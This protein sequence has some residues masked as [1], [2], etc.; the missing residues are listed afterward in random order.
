MRIARSVGVLGSLL[1]LLTAQQQKPAVEPAPQQE[2][3]QEERV[4]RIFRLPELGRYDADLPV[5]SPP[6]AY[7]LLSVLGRT[8]AAAKWDVVR[9]VGVQGGDW[10]GLDVRATKV[11]IDAVQSVFEQ[12]QK[13]EPLQVG[14]Q[15]SVVTLPWPVAEALNL[16]NRRT[17][18]VDAETVDKLVREA[19]KNKGTLC[20]LP[21][22]T[23]GTLAPFVVESP[24]KPDA[25]DE[26][27][28]R[29]L[30]EMVPLDDREVAVAMHLV[31]GVLPV[32]KT[33]EPAGALL[34]PVL[35]LQAGKCALATV[36]EGATATVLVVRG[37]DVAAQAPP[38]G[39][40]LLAPLA[41]GPCCR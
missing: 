17:V 22:V 21:E 37:I 7:R 31:R 9:A 38:A 34:Q 10:W 28:L 13:D 25:K 15:C 27:K 11:E 24:R 12:L 40:A 32:D 35:R 1:S 18:A 14:L 30:G 8:F 16:Q 23:A 41:M 33:R 5:G 2:A 26:S 3:R 36:R 29:L 4:P 20:N 19:T 6:A 39:E